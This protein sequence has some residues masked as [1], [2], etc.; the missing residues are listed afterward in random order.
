MDPSNRW[1]YCLNEDSD[2]IAQFSVDDSDG[3]LSNT[4]HAWHTGSPVCMVFSTS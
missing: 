3:S 4:G 2:T 1:L